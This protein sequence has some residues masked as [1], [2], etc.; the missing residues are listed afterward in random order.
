M[1]N[2][3]LNF[4]IGANE[5]FICRNEMPI[6]TNEIH[7]FE[8][9]IFIYGNEMPISTNNSTNNNTLFNEGKLG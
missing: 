2:F 1:G 8:N 7:I 4:Y 5:I 6:G 9:E 3:D